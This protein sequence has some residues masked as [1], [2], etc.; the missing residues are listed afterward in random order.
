MIIMKLTKKRMTTAIGMAVGITLLTGAA[1][2]SYNTSNGYEI[3]KTAIKGLMQNDNYTAECKIALLLDGENVNTTTFKELYDRNG[4]VKLN[5]TDKSETSEAYENYIFANQYEE[6]VQ[7]N[8]KITVYHRADG[9]EESSVYEDYGEY[10]NRG[11]VIFCKSSYKI[12]GP[13]F[14]RRGVLHQIE[15]LGNRA[16]VKFFCNF[17][18]YL[19]G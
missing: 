16:V 2:A 9:T 13:G 11:R 7:D 12:F 14:L 5:R 4:D 17:Y 1:F 18:L 3:G 10:Y 19:R 6:Y 15:Y 8:D